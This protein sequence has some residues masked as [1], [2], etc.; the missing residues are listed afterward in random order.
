MPVREGW[1]LRSARKLLSVQS[2][3]T[4]AYVSLRLIKGLSLSL[5]LSLCGPVG[6]C[7][8]TLWMFL[9]FCFGVNEP[10]TLCNV[11]WWP[12]HV[13][14]F[15]LNHAVWLVW[16]SLVPVPLD[17]SNIPPNLDHIMCTVLITSWATL[18]THLFHLSI[19]L[20][21]FLLSVNIY[22][23][24]LIFLLIFILILVSHF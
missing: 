8:M 17:E 19:L 9:F 7:I 2:W 6:S 18:N 14:G 10:L 20:S 22:H 13:P 21:I 1:G 12:D 11:N 23:F 16:V 4:V 15:K 24:H 5:S 3:V